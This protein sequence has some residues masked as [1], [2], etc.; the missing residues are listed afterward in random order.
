MGVS[1]NLSRFMNKLKSKREVA[2][3]GYGMMLARLSQ[4]NGAKLKVLVI[5]A[6]MIAMLCKPTN[7]NILAW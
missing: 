4:P 6:Q 5:S 7:L 3:L 2:E 1:P